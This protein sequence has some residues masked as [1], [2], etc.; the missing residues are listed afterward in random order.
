ME[1]VRVAA[2]SLVGRGGPVGVRRVARRTV[3]RFIPEEPDP[4]LPGR[5]NRHYQRI[6]RRLGTSRAG[7]GKSA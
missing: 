4:T 7:Y 2:D 5:L 1:V 6:R 3:Q